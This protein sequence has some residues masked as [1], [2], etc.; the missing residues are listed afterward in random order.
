MFGTKKEKHVDQEVFAI[1]DSKAATYQQPIFA[2]NSLIISRE[3][4]AMFTDPAQRNNFIVTNSEDFTLFKIGEYDRKT[5]AYTP[6]TP[7]AIF[8]M[9]EIKAAALHKMGPQ[10]PLRDVSQ[11]YNGHS[12]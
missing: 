5:A 8:G 9:H 4:E 7:E 3:I 10:A 11:A 2:T 6:I 12:V 1:Y